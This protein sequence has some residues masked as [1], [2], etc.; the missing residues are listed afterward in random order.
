[1]CHPQRSCNLPEDDVE[2]CTKIDGGG[3]RSAGEEKEDFGDLG[4]DGRIILRWICRKWDVWAWIG[5]SWLKIGDGN[6]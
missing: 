4:V 6:L 2:K 3:G 1:L 5:S